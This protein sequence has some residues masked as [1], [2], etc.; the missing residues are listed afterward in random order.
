MF[1][2]LA[3]IVALSAFSEIQ[4]CGK[5]P[6]TAR[7]VGGQSALP[8]AWPWQISLQTNWGSP[9]CG[10]ALIHPQWV[11]TAAHCLEKNKDPKEWQVEAGVHKVFYT[12]KYQ[13]TKTIS[14][15]IMHEK[16]NLNKK[17]MNDIALLKLSS[18][19][20]TSPQVNTVC[21][22]AQGQKA[23]TGSQCYIAGWGKVRRGWSSLT[24]QQAMIPIADDAKCRQRNS[25]VWWVDTNLMI[26]AG[27]Q[28]KG[29][30]QGDSGGPLVCEEGAGRWVVRGVISWGHK[31]CR[32]DYYTVS[33][34]ISTYVDWINNKINGGKK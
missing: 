1:W 15:I 28:G 33:T 32:T 26:C 24:L 9:R 8:H 14:Q 5:K 27:G 23:V 16:Y 19:V 3:L 34:R 10:G 7:I 31:K 13:Q 2:Y 18:P 12:T 4:G 6:F 20:K 11:V 30:C 25:E 17:L 21:L 22:P 29:A